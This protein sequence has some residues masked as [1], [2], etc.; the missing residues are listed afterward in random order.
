MNV[1][2][3]GLTELNQIDKTVNKLSEKL[4]KLEAALHPDNKVQTN[5]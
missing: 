2:K 3:K 4:H 5:S 1:Q